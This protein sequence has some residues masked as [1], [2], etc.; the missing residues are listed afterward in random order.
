MRA[1]KKVRVVTLVFAV[2]TLLQPAAACLAAVQEVVSSGVGRLVDNVPTFADTALLWATIPDCGDPGPNIQ[3]G[4]M[5]GDELRPYQLNRASLAISG[6]RTLYEFNPTRPV[7][8]CNPYRL[9]SNIF[10]FGPDLYFVDNQGPDGHAALW[11]R[12]RDSNVGDPSRMLVDMGLDT[13]GVE[14]I[15]FGV[16]VIMIRASNNPIVI[17]NN[18]VQYHKD[19]GELL[20]GSIDTGDARSL[21]NLRYD[22]RYLYWIKN[23]AL[24]RNDTTDG[25]LVDALPGRRIEAYVVYGYE[26]QCGPPGCEFLSRI[27]FSSGNQLFEAETLNNQVFPVYASSDPTSVIVA[28]ERGS[29]DYFFIELRPRGGGFEQDTFRFYRLGVGNTVPALIYGPITDNPLG[30]EGFRTDF[31]WLYFR[32]IAR[33]RLLRLSTDEV[34]IPIVDLRATGLEVTQG[35]QNSAGSLQ[36]IANKRTIVRFYARSGTGMD[37][38]GVE[39]SLAGGNEF[40][41]LGR[42]EPVNAGG[43]LITVRAN[44]SRTSLDQSFQF[45]LP[46]YWTTG[47]RLSLTATVNPAGRLIEDVES[48]NNASREVDFLASERLLVIYYNWSYNLGGALRTPSA[49]DVATSRNR[50]RRLYPLGEPGDAFESPGLHTVVLD[51]V[52]DGLTSQVDR[53]NAGCIQRYPTDADP[54]KDKSGDRNMCASDYVHGRMKALRQGSSIAAGAVSYGN[55]AQAPAPMGLSYFTRGYAGGQFASGPSTDPNYASHEVGHVLGRPHPLPGALSCGHSPDDADYPYNGARIDTLPS[56]AETRYQGLNFTDTDIKTLMLLDAAGTYDTMSYCSP[57]WISDYTF[58]GMYQYLAS[59]TRPRLARRAPLQAVPGDWLIASGTLDPPGG[60]G[61]FAV[62]QR[63]NSVMDDTAP[64]AG[65]FTLE[66]RNGAGGLVASH[67]FTA[68]PIADLP[69]AVSFDLVVRFVPGTA[70]LRA[71]EDATQRVLATKSVSTNAPLIGDVRLQNAPDPVDG[72]VAVVWTAS[73]NDGDALTFDVFASRDDGA[74]YRPIHLGI[75]T[76]GVAL[77]TSRLGGG[78]NRLRVVASDG[79]HTAYAESAPFTVPE[80]APKVLITSPADGFRADW[81]QFVTLQAQVDDL[82]DEFIPD[83]DILWISNRIGGA[84]ATGRIVQIERL[85]V[86]ENVLEV[87][88]INSRGEVGTD[89]I[90]VFIGDVLAAPG[91]TLS[92]APQSIGWHIAGDDTTP[93]VRTINVDNAG[94]DR[95]VFD[96]SSDA[97]WLLIDSQMAIADAVAPQSFTVIANPTSLPAG[98]TSR[99][100]LTFENRDDPDDVVV[101]PVELSRGNVFDH[102][103]E[104]SQ[105]ACA[106]DC[107]DSG[108]VLISELVR[109]V[110]IALGNT[111]IDE[112]TALD[113]NGDGSIGINELV[114]AVLAALN[115][116]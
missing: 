52:D 74:N 12:P 57:Y 5:P 94:E 13:T 28:V 66:L 100:N 93:Q 116:C 107:D 83:G 38:A 42:L 77:D 102:T 104:E 105:A 46:L 25:N 20:N 33:N 51:F 95:L 65:G 80:R 44:P 109:G 8:T 98:I 41:F 62:V 18:I 60:G 67:P 23:G 115:G 45:E 82:Q 90:T 58:D 63:T 106:G 15:V 54:A 14:I 48:D 1:R 29:I 72:I 16:S 86:G 61:G 24:R 71:I 70:E 73:D 85:P 101:V 56:D 79:V 11:R 103:G 2:L 87:E 30:Y 114:G 35:L 3:R 76:S 19:T 75:A 96:V 111:S 21:S 27:L 7:A 50:M 40:G 32:D 84:F 4:G 91:P 64:V 78:S 47:G 113:A 39:A 69:G 17:P 110:N 37:V 22:G 6:V 9:L 88:A 10:A 92:V 55:I 108:R 26:E 43:K 89:T 31:T 112:C 97:P 59:P 68:E 34:A 36:Q 53:T 99:A 49:T 81:G